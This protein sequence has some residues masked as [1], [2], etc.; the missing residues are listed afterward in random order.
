M[1]ATDLST[2]RSNLVG[3]GGQKTFFFLKRSYLNHIKDVGFTSVMCLGD[4]LGSVDVGVLRT[5]SAHLSLPL[6]GD[7]TRGRS[8]RTSV[9]TLN[10]AFPRWNS[11][12]PLH[13]YFGT[14]H[15]SELL[16]RYSLLGTRIT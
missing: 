13:S 16:L 14:F 1:P 10:S 5:L 15:L 2:E 12:L 3:S 4:G 11:S 6:V 7:H 8:P 9:C